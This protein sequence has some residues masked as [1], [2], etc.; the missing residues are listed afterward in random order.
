MHLSRLDQPHSCEQ[1]TARPAGHGP[2]QKQSCSLLPPEQ[3]EAPIYFKPPCPVSCAASLQ[4]RCT[5]RCSRASPETFTESGLP[6]P[7]PPRSETSAP[8]WLTQASR[9]LPATLGR[10]F[11]V[12]RSQHQTSPNSIPARIFET[13][14]QAA[15][16]LN[17]LQI[18]GMFTPSDS[19]C[20]H[21][22][23]VPTWHAEDCLLGI[24]GNTLLLVQQRI[25]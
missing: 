5:S 14:I 18:R 7:C 2:L 1:S 9:C 11:C 8:P 19:L 6:V 12:S 21:P 16:L 24:N 22:Q 15:V 13:C 17:P 4:A 23:V 20:S 3:H 25:F 10:C